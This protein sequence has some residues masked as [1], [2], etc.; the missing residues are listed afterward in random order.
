MGWDF[1]EAWTSKDDI[2]ALFVGARAELAPGWTALG[3]A[4]TRELNEHVLWVA[5]DSPDGKLVA[6]ILAERNRKTGWWGYKSMDETM[7]PF[8]YS[9]PAHILALAT[10]GPDAGAKWR[11]KLAAT[12]TP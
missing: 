4:W 8:Y 5:L 1:C 11:A 2:A 12:V 7:G 3:H 9:C 6:C 10:P